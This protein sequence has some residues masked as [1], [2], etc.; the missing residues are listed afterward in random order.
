MRKR[1]VLVAQSGGPTA[2]INA[3]LAGVVEQAVISGK[4]GKVYGA[5]YGIKGVLADDLIDISEILQETH[6]MLRLIH[7]PSSALGSCRHKL[8]SAEDDPD[9]YKTIFDTFARYDIG[10][11]VYI[12]GND[13]MDTVHKLSEYAI[14]QGIDVAIMGAPKTIDNDLYGMD[15]SPGFGSAARY[16]AT[17]FAEIWCDAKV[18]DTPAVTI[19]ETM[20]R[21]VGW[22]CASSALARKVGA[23]PQLIY[24]PEV[25]FDD[26]KFLEDVEEQLSLSPSLVIAIS[27][28]IRRADGKFVNEDAGNAK[29]DAFGHK[30]MGGACRVLENLINN[31]MECK[32]RCID[33]S[34]MQRCAAHL[35]SPVDLAEAKALGAMSLAR[36]L[37]GV[38]G[39]VSVLTR[40]SDHPYRV[41]Y[42]TV[43]ATT[44][45]NREKAIPREWINARGNFVTD[46]L[47][48]YV[49]PLIGVPFSRESCSDHLCLY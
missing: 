12:G 11:F 2:A 16:I 37:E 19:V 6:A 48:R 7:T 27:E 29:V 13:S 44:I 39:E 17:T 5:K 43:H 31:H 47:I 41:E 15:H 22:L 46:E 30:H 33:L 49:E 26:N 4:V 36:A 45:A 10:Y 18:Y 14:K 1:N 21:H 38:S 8:K 32:V 25:P 42:S 9:T 20:G 24:L 40:V 35:A 34:L 23:A 28:G 3:T